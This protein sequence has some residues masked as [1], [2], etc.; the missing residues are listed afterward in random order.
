MIVIVASHFSNSN[1]ILFF[2]TNIINAVL[3]VGF[4]Y[5]RNNLLFDC[6]FFS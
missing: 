5:S 3:K 6:N 4:A 2:I 1:S